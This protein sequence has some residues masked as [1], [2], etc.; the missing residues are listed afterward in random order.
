MSEEELLDCVMELDTIL[1]QAE[2]FLSEKEYKIALHKIREARA[3]I[4]ELRE[5]DESGID[6]REDIGMDIMNNLK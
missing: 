4:E 3:A 5:E 1:S 2:S 6:S